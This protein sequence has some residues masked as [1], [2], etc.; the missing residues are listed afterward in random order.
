MNNKSVGFIGG[1]RITR[2]FLGR[3][4]PAQKFPGNITVSDPNAE[5]LSN[6]KA[7]FPAL[8]TTPDNGRAA[9]H[10]IVF[11]AVHPADMAD[12]A[13]GIRGS[14]KPGTI[15]VSLAPKPALAKVTELLGGFARLAWVIPTA[16]SLIGAGYNPVAFGPAL[17]AAEKGEVTSLLRPLG[18]CPEVAEEVVEAYG[19]LTTMGLNLLMHKLAI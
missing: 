16:P 1:G 8:N 10:D 4:T 6:L 9:S 2:I 7:H 3:W 15:V 14:L 13:V 12:V 5:S 11:L 19:V 18:E 17:S